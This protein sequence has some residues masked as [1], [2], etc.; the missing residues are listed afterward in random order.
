MLQIISHRAVREAK[1][2]G[3][4]SCD[5]DVTPTTN[6]GESIIIEKASLC[7][8][9]VLGVSMTPHRH[10]TRHMKLFFSHEM[11]CGEICDA[12]TTTTPIRK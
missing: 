10:I 11:M 12:N 6:K 2:M 8:S 9:K 3:G 7:S 1:K 5:A 4:A